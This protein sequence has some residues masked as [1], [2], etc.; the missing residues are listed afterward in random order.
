MLKK[1]RVLLHTCCAPCFT[2][3]YNQTKDNFAVDSFWYNPNIYPEAELEKRLSELEK[4]SRLKKFLILNNSNNYLKENTEWQKKIAG[5]ENEPEGGKRCEI[6]IRFRL[7]KTAKEANKNNYNY[8]GTTLT[9]SPHKN[10]KVI[11]A[12]GNELMK[13]YDIPFLVAD[14]KKNNGYQKSVELCK[15]YNIYRQNYC[16]CEYSLN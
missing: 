7:E 12:I 8:F 9:V 3:A 14:F 16:G 2:S 15:Q 4:Y 1:P 13:K 6:C 11:N 10:V 5:L